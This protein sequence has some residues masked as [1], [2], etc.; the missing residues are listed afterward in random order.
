MPDNFDQMP[1]SAVVACMR[2]VSFSQDGGAEPDASTLRFITV[3]LVA[4]VYNA[5]HDTFAQLPG[6]PTNL[7]LQLH[8]AK[9]ALQFIEEGQYSSVFGSGLL[10]PCHHQKCLTRAAGT[11]RD[12]LGLHGLPASESAGAHSPANLLLMAQKH[13]TEW[14]AGNMEHSTISLI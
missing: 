12:L 14:K 1:D 11:R 6:M 9:T 10:V 7:P 13:E 5:A 2:F 8:N 4:Y 3:L